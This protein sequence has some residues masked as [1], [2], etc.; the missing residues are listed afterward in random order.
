MPID[1]RRST[2]LEVM[3]NG[4]MRRALLGEMLN[5]RVKCPA[6]GWEELMLEEMHIAGMKGRAVG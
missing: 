4:G 3:H 6:L 2:I 1:E 5:S